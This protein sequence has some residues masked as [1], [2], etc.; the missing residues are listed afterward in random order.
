LYYS[1]NIEKIQL[2]SSVATNHKAIADTGTSLLAIPPEV[3]DP[4]FKEPA[5]EYATLDQGTYILECSNI[6]K[7]P[8]L[9]FTIG[10][11]AFEVKA[12]QYILPL[13]ENYCQVGIM[14]YTPPN[15]LIVLGDVFLRTVV[16]VFDLQ[17]ETI[18]FAPATTSA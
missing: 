5:F 15:G 18:G 1:L 16:A 3:A 9:E 11:T 17:N 10:G 7:F 8:S 12:E 14:T 6:D 2:G 13:E 4:F